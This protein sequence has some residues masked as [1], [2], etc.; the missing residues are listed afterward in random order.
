MI[1]RKVILT[2]KRDYFLY[3]KLL[4]IRGFPGH[5]NSKESVCNAGDLSSVPGWEDPLEKGMF[6]HS[7]ILA[8]GI[9]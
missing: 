7:R 3:W 5:S 6:T 2:T 4:I 9:P 1:F 8:W